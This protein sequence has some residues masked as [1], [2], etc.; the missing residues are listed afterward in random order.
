MLDMRPDCDIRNEYIQTK[1]NRKM[2]E[3]VL[4]RLGAMGTV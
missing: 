4:F 1:K 3:Y 2:A